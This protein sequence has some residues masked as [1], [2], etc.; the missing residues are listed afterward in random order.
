MPDL[1]NRGIR[2][3]ERG[4]DIAGPSVVAYTTEE[5]DYRPVREVA[6]AHAKGHDCVVI[7]YAA[8]T[9]GI[10][11]EPMPN[12]I[13][14]DGADARF[15]GRL[16]LADLEYLGRAEV[17][18]Q[19]VEARDAGARAAAWLPKGR[20]MDALAEYARAQDAHIVF[21]PDNL[22]ADDELNALLNEPKTSAKVAQSAVQIQVVGSSIKEQF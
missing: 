5:D 2:S 13:D 8:D 11:S 1:E 10:L 20:G 16:G 9:A 17:A 12:A 21:L 15:G 22:A 19:V 14:A 4:E 18:R 3:G 6:Q 7:L